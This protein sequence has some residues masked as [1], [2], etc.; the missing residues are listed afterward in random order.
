[1]TPIVIGL[2]GQKGVG[3]T[4]VATLCTKWEDYAIAD[5][6]KNGLT[7]MCSLNRS[8]LDDPDT[9]DHALVMIGTHVLISDVRYLHNP[10]GYT[11]RYT[12]T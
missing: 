10:D 7:T 9:K 4:T 12:A 3:E 2:V 6:L 5:S 1:M 11:T 8:A